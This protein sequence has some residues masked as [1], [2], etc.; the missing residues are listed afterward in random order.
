LAFNGQLPLRS[1]FPTIKLSFARNERKLEKAMKNYRKKQLQP[2]EPWTP[3]TDMELVSVSL[4]DKANG[5]PRTGDMIAVNPTT[6][7][8]RWLVA[9]EF[10]QA[11]YKEA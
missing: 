2:M 5:S 11:N 10:F 9:A 8:D 3:E 4:A 6:P 7:K 1:L